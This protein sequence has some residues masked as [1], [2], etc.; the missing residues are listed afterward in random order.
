MKTIVEIKQALA[1]QR[2]EVAGDRQAVSF[3]ASFAKQEGYKIVSHPLALVVS[4][5]AGWFAG[6][7]SN[8]PKEVKQVKNVTIK[9]SGLTSQLIKM[10]APY[11]ISELRTEKI[12][13][14]VQRETVKSNGPQSDPDTL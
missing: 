13:K 1:V 8:R 5:A 7:F 4:F 11:V 6:S 14:E 3:C 9:R 10:V 2:A 12:V